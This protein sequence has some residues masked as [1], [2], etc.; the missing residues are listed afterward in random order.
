MSHLLTKIVIGILVIT[1]I[2]VLVVLNETREMARDAVRKADMRQLM[3]VQIAYYVDFG[4]HYEYHGFPPIIPLY[5]ATPTDPINEW[6][7]VYRAISNVGQP[8][9][10]CYF[11]KLE[12]GGYYVVSPFGSFE[13]ALIPPGGFHECIPPLDYLWW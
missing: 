6:P 7:Y 2:I 1:V 13:R 3:A 8:N 12:G 5:L 10:F 11:A 4:R 9:K